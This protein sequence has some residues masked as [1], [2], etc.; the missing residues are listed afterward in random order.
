M[1][2][3]LVDSGFNGWIS[4]FNMGTIDAGVGYRILGYIMAVLFTAFAALSTILLKRVHTLYRTTGAS[5]EKAQA[6][7]ATGVMKNPMAQQAATQAASAAVQQTIN[8]PQSR[9]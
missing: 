3:G 9:Y 4:A 5:F 8:N 7:F 6:E 2:V 1:T